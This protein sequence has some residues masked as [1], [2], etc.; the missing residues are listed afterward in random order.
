MFYLQYH[1]PDG[2]SSGGSHNSRSH[3][4]PPT[5]GLPPSQNPPQPPQMSPSHVEAHRAR[6]NA[7]G[8]TRMS[9][10]KG[11]DSLR[12]GHVIPRNMSGRMT[13]RIV[14]HH[15]TAG[16]R[17]GVM[18]AKSDRSTANT[19]TP[20]SASSGASRKATAP[21]RLAETVEQREVDDKVGR[22]GVIGPDL[23][24]QKQHQVQQVGPHT[25]Q[26]QVQLPHQSR[27]EPGT[28]TF[29]TTAP[30][31]A[32]G[33][34]NASSSQTAVQDIK[35]K[36]VTGPMMR[37]ITPG[38]FDGDKVKPEVL[39]QRVDAALKAALK[40]ATGNQRRRIKLVS[41]SEHESD[42]DDDDEGSSWSDDESNV[43]EP[44]EYQQQH[45]KQQHRHRPP[46]SSARKD[47]QTTESGDESDDNGDD[48]EHDGPL[49]R[50]AKE[51]ERQ[52]NMFAKLP[53][54]SYAD[55]RRKGI[56]AGP[57]N[58][59]LLLNPPPEM[60]PHEH[61]YRILSRQSR[62]AGDIAYH[63]AGGFGYGSQE[64]QPLHAHHQYQQQQRGYGQ[65]QKQ[66]QRQRSQ[67]FYGNGRSSAQYAVAPPPQPRQRSV[68]PVQAQAQHQPHPQQSNAK[69]PTRERVGGFG[70]FQFTVMH[71]VDPKAPKQPAPA[72]APA[73]VLA[74]APAAQRPQQVVVAPPPSAASRRASTGA[75]RVASTPPVLLRSL[76]KSSALNPIIQQVTAS[77]FKDAPLAHSAHSHQETDLSPKRA[78]VSPRV[79]RPGNRLSARPDDVELSDSEDDGS[80][81]AIPSPKS[82]IRSPKSPIQEGGAKAQLEAV[83]NGKPKYPA[84]S[85]ATAVTPGGLPFADGQEPEAPIEFSESVV[86]K[87][88]THMEGH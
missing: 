25:P 18:T 14:H 11:K 4:T 44:Q 84:G 32:A 87:L 50:A 72:P 81:Q 6:S 67:P 24:T 42:D 34:T 46:L 22:V 12:H 66:M 33:N 76:S 39:D 1:S 38:L 59:T 21:R 75:S 70:G 45:Q 86:C 55:L 28:S 47:S 61:P 68:T 80:E 19:L 17:R 10:R 36:N 54:E 56:G 63:H 71:P 20:G 79:G 35:V 62:S 9:A 40:G 16:A 43:G 3:L 88:V 51:A 48:D 65:P 15:H 60:F 58:L 29:T 13:A 77:S 57:S 27:S 31:A 74:Q 41:S 69:P 64:Q 2:S 37:L 49:A 85:S 52:R 5:P 30:A 26:R 7:A 78:T 23:H 83:M 73:P 8:A 82:M 53:R